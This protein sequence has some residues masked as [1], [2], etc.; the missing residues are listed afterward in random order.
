MPNDPDT[1][2]SCPGRRPD[3]LIPLIDLVV[4]GDSLVKAKRVTVQT[5]IDAAK[6]WRG[7]GARI[8]R[9]AAALVREGVGSPMESRLRMLL[10]LAGLP[11]PIVD[12]K[13]RDAQ[14]HVIMRYDLSYPSHR[15]IIE[16]DGRQHAESDTQRDRDIDRREDIDRRQ[17]RIV[18]IRSKDIYQTP[19]NTLLR[20]VGAMID[21]KMP[22]PSRLRYDWSRHF[23][24]LPNDAAPATWPPRDVEAA[25][26]Q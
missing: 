2:I 12:Y 20:I 22:V 23:P 25:K 15:L 19:R 4:L 21:Q 10:I 1:H 7:H 24:S 16:Y 8:A 11:E 13:V 26:P 18:V 9:Q 5:L 6:V 3:H 17:W 14:G